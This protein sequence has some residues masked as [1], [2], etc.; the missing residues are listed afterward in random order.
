MKLK[1][2]IRE[3]TEKTPAIHFDEAK[4]LISIKGKSIPEHTGEFYKALQEW[5]EEYEKNPQ[6]KTNV[7]I[8]LEY[9]NTSSSK[10]LMDIF[11][12]LEAIHKNGH[13]MV[14]NWYYEEDDEDMFESGEDHDS[15]IDIPFK[16]ISVPVED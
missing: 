6:H 9:Y 8:Q 3:A 13:D 1:T 5:I 2:I 4:G 12:K 14:V 11:R 16:I 15:M 10:A 7:E